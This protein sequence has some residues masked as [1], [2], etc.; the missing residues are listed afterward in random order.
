MFIPDWDTSTSSSIEDV[1]NPN[2]NSLE[3][4]E[5][6][7]AYY[8]HERDK[9]KIIPQLVPCCMLPL[10]TVSLMVL[11]GLGIAVV[12]PLCT[13]QQGAGE[14]DSHP[15]AHEYYILR[16]STYVPSSQLI[17]CLFALLLLLQLLL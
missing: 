3:E 17:V 15:V 4:E 1:T 10:A 7:T 9:S 8:Y 12:S 6:P 2:Y 16:R 14:H 11:M 13:F 5:D